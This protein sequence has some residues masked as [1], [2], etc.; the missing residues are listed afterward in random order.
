MKPGTQENQEVKL[1]RGVA[2]PDSPINK[3][4]EEGD[5]DEIVLTDDD[6]DELWEILNHKDLSIITKNKLR[7]HIETNPH[8]PDTFI[9]YYTVLVG[10]LLKKKTF[11]KALEAAEKAL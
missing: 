8:N 7:K 5:F 1:T 2:T 11:K 6:E 10:G 4:Y 9:L 3:N